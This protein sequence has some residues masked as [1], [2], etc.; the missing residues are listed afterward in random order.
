M[1]RPK[2]GLGVCI[3]K[4][5]KVLL[6]KRKKAHGSG[7]WSFPG[8]HLEAGESFEECARRE[9]TE[10]AGIEIKNIAFITAT[11]DV[12]PNEDK[13]YITIYMLAEYESGEV[14]N[15]EP[16]K[17]E[18]WSWFSWDALPHPL[19]IPMQNLIKTGFTP[20]AQQKY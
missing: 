8:G 9:T 4:D 6:G 5:G 20:F 1:E 11:N 7:S 3:I 13:H 12:M 2:V 16:E 18:G 10:E 14:S 17:L 15:R 19:F